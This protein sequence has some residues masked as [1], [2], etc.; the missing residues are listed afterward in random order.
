MCRVGD[1]SSNLSYESL[2]S[3]ETRQ[4]LQGLPISDPDFFAELTRNRDQG[5]ELTED[6]ATL[7]DSEDLDLDVPGDDSAVPLEAVQDLVHGVLPIDDAEGAFKLGE[8]GLILAAEAEETLVE[9]IEGVVVDTT[10]VREQDL[11]RGKRKK[12][13]NRHYF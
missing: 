9:E 11:G 7:E 3:P 10:S 1:S 4:V 5:P 13:R 8:D 12:F 6:D 2:T